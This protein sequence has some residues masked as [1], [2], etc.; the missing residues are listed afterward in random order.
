MDD[1]I[2]QKGKWIKLEKLDRIVMDQT[3]KMD[4]IVIMDQIGKVN[5][6]EKMDQIRKNGPNNLL[7]SSS[8]KVR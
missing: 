2:D 1:K 4:W 8:K 3:G 7:F 6:V 5:Q